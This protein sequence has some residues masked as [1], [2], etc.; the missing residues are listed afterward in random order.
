[1]KVALLIS[2]YLRNYDANVKFIKD[3][4]IQ[5]FGNVDVY[6]HI[7]K[8]ESD[9]DKYLNTVDEEKDT[10]YIDNILSP[11][12]KII[13]PNILFCNN[14]AQ[15][16]I[17]N[18]WSKLYKLNTILKTN[19]QHTGKK[20]DLVVR[21]RPD[22]YL[23]NI[24]FTTTTEHIIIPKDSKIDKS[25]LTNNLDPHLC[26]AFA[27][28]PSDEMDKYFKIFEHLPNL[29]EKYG[30]VPET[31]LYYYLKKCNVNYTLKNINYGY[32]L[33]KCNVIA[34]C[35]DSGSGKTTLS[36]SLKQ[37][38]NNSFTL[39]CDRY[40]KWDR[41]N[42]QWQN[43]T[44]LNPKANFITKMN[45]DIFD[46]KIGKSIYQVDYDHKTGT[47]T[48]REHIKNANNL[49]VCGLHCLYNK[50][51]EIY[52]LKIYIDTEPKLKTKWKLLRDTKAR[53][54]S[55]KNVLEQI[56]KRKNDYYKYIYPQKELSDIIVNFFEPVKRIESEISLRMYIN[57]KYFLGNVLNSFTQHGI[58]YEINYNESKD[59]NLI[60]FNTF[61]DTNLLQTSKF[62]RNDYYD[63]IVFLIFN[64]NTLPNNE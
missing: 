2:G 3:K 18:H 21:Y 1:M 28:G 33:S 22:V 59:F 60:T 15:N 48:E 11:I 46:L 29:I 30:T 17:L 50:N 38:F 8:H 7:T 36:N 31:I 41:G 47:F 25:R 4:I 43:I 64:L 37:Y 35:G 27:Y 9:Q 63:Y 26:D 45:K 12:C 5:Q 54:H 24:N 6:I 55:S 14:A 16:N 52:N 13:E 44:H 23:E 61:K 62:K 58:N 19:E 20:Y 32:V 40:H 49:I 57:K 53:G 39:E 56:N 10:K 34:I 42:K 51:N